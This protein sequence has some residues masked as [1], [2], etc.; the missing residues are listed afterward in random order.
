M[1]TAQIKAQWSISLECDCPN[2]KEY[3]NLAEEDDFWCDRRVDV[4]EHDTKES[5]N[6]DVVCP[7]CKH[8]FKVCCWY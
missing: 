1:E 4:C 5:N 2:C 8:H 6:L 7:E 3:V